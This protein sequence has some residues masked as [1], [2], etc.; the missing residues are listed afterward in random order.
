MLAR[1][2]QL[3]RIEQP[4]QAP[5]AIQALQPWQPRETPQ[6]AGGWRVPGQSAAAVRVCPGL[7]AGHRQ[8][9]PDAPDRVVF[10]RL[11][12]DSPRPTPA[13]FGPNQANVA[14][15]AIVR[16]VTPIPAGSGAGADS[17]QPEVRLPVSWM[18]L[19]RTIAASSPTVATARYTQGYDIR[20]IVVGVR[21][22]R[23]R[24][25]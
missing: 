15:P 21:A 3:L 6:A 22:M 10:P 8:Q 1:G 2:R 16:P 12:T 9:S 25:G 7:R 14:A 24:Q 17:T 23:A 11:R 13:A 4:G 5:A 20:N 18:S 19:R